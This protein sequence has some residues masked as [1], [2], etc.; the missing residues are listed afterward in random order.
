MPEHEFSRRPQ[1]I[2]ATGAGSPKGRRLG[3]KVGAALGALALTGA[4][5]FAGTAV[6]HESAS[7]EAATEVA[8]DQA[9]FGSSSLDAG[10]LGSLA[11]ADETSE[12]GETDGT[13]A[14]ESEATGRDADAAPARPN[15]ESGEGS[16]EG[17]TSYAVRGDVVQLEDEDVLVCATGNGF[18]MSHIG[19]TLA[20][21]VDG[22]TTRAES[23]HLCGDAFR[24]VGALFVADPAG[25]DM[26]SAPRDVNAAGHAYQ[27]RPIADEV[28]RCT[29][30]D[31]TMATLWSAAP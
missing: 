26:L 1:V 19:T 7:T 23:E 20:E 28:L 3:A 4:G 11:P 6:G 17:R 31:G 5:F 29:A 10:S 22:E 13:G 9:L 12:A 2:P 30:E 18:G 14:T 24:L 16:S 8:Y 25:D 27:C 15:P 21:G